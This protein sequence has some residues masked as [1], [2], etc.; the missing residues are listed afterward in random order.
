MSNLRSSRPILIVCDV[1]M[2]GLGSI[3]TVSLRDA[4]MDRLSVAIDVARKANWKI[5]HTGI[6]FPPAYR[7]IPSH[8]KLY[9]GFQRLHKLW[10]E[11]KAHWF[12]EGYSGSEPIQFQSD[13]MVVWRS[14]HMPT[15]ELV[16]QVLSSVDHDTDNS[17]NNNAVHATL[18]G[19]H[20]GL[21]IQA[22]AQTLCDAG[23]QVQ[24]VRECVLDS[25][26]TRGEAVLDHLIPTYATVISL[27]EFVDQGIGLNHYSIPEEKMNQSP[28][29]NCKKKS[30]GLYSFCNRSGH[31]RLYL[32]H[33][34]S[35]WH[36]YPT[37][38]WYED[39]FRTGKQFL[40]PLVQ[41]VVDLCD[42]PQFS[43][44]SMFLKGRE[45][46][47]EKEKVVTLAQEFMPRT[48]RLEQHRQWVGEDPTLKEDIDDGKQ[49]W[50]LKETDK[51]GGRA[52]QAFLS[53]GACLDAADVDRHY[54]VQRHVSK[55]LLTV[56]GHKCHVKQYAYLQSTSRDCV[57]DTD[58]CTYTPRGTTWELYMHQDPF[59]CISPNPWD[60]MDTGMATQVTI[61]RDIQL[62][63]GQQCPRW[64][65]WPDAYG[66][67]RSILTTVIRRAIEDERLQPRPTKQFELFSADFLLD[68]TGQPW[69]LEFNFTPV[70][71]DPLHPQELTTNGLREYHRRFRDCDPT[72]S[73][74]INDHDMIRDA[75]QM[76][77]DGQELSSTSVPQGTSNSRWEK[78]MTL[79][80][81]DQTVN[82]E[83]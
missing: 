68:V 3:E 5:I 58:A 13:D 33:L 12:L 49:L 22:I 65:G 21:A 38:S 42:E 59:L 73:S 69:L 19:I 9:G 56:D 2:D 1:Q 82:Y 14:Q 50:F 60:P 75:L 46:L 71:F 67:C 20:T 62:I 77:L 76:A 83:P 28:N 7:G 36:S 78:V 18:V 34:S 45:W 43:R 15:Q 47:D 27:E 10:G 64:D 63:H 79:E 72:D 54:V 26:P 35:D 66:K 17:T 80:K 25:N 52:V 61:L 30:F 55:P 11:E 29:D 40:C 24:V 48:Y 53:L 39:S 32:P 37:Q 44:I 6:R 16:N 41:R 8:H 23:V 57:D 31:F 4:W 51:N 81:S 70:L 74:I